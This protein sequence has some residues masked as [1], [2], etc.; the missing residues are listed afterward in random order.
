MSD[1]YKGAQS[2]N[3]S[4]S[5]FDAMKFL[6]TQI[7]SK[8]NTATLVQVKSVTNAGEVAEVG[9]VSIQPLVAQLDGYGNS[10]PH[11][12]INDIPYFR[13]Q[14]GANA[15][16]LD[17]QPGDIGMAVFANKDISS[18]KANAAA[19]IAGKDPVPP[20]SARRFD[21]ADGLY[22]GGVLNG[23]PTQYVQFS[24]DGIKI[25]SPTKIT[26]EAPTVQIDTQTA[27]VNASTS[28]AVTAPSISLG[29]SGQSL[30]SF[31]TSAFTAL[32]NGHTHASSGA[33]VPNQQMG[34]S[35]LTSTVKGG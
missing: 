6:V 32:F 30:L 12:V 3:S 15:V 33:G 21:M 25:H 28:A 5:D 19:I 26:C 22:V 35:Q 31:V 20:G 2:P 9:Y 17:P 23:T 4:A 8:A 7:L 1:G 16:I 24:A 29:A 18:V 14:G 13:M 34:S 11:G 10:F 27:T